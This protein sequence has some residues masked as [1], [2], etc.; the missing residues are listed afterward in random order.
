M[1]L[2]YIQ[3]KVQ[4]AKKECLELCINIGSGHVTSAFSCAEIVCVLY[5]AVMNV[6]PRHPDAPGRDRFVMSKNHG[7]V[8]VYPVL[9]DIGFL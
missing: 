3:K 9:K 7:M 8:M 4:N 5:Y 2:D 6:D 1:E